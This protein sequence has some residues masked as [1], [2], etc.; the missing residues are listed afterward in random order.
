M[1]ERPKLVATSHRPGPHTCV[2]VSR[3]LVVRDDMTYAIG[4]YAMVAPLSTERT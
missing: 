4:R 3:P 1:D 2:R